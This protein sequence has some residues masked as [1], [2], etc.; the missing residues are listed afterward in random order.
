M[1]HARATD[2]YDYVIEA[3]QKHRVQNCTTVYW[4][5]APSSPKI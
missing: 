1:G 3:S 4:L 5:M 2:V